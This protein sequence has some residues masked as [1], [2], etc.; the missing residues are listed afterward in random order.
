VLP[1]AAF[2]FGD[3]QVGVSLHALAIVVA[4]VV[5]GAV[6]LRRA[7]DRRLVLLAVPA[8]ALAGLV[9][10]RALFR[11]LH[12]GA[13]VWTGGL[14]S[15]G[16]VAAGLAAAWL[17]AHSARRPVVDVLDPLAPAAIVALGIGRIGCYLGGCCFG[18]PTALPWGVVFPA[19]GPPARHPLQLYSAAG[20]LA[21]AA[22]L[23]VRA[24]PGV[25]TRR[26]C[27]GLGLLRLV[28]E[29]WRDPGATDVLAAGWLT[30][31][32]AAALTLVAGGLVLARPG[33]ID[34]A[35]AAEDTR[36]WRMRSR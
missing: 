36:R 28:L 5:G 32:Q 29:T 7:P 15:T 4:V 26:A 11:L 6:G 1:R 34:Y 9:G 12:G 2:V 10:A 33:G 25:V 19:L 24:P 23:L 14:A 30:L 17:V 8:V 27:V 31:P 13:G 18:A 20:D 3:V 22:L 16:G 35:S 21:L